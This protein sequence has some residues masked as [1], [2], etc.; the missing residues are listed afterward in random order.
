[1]GDNFKVWKGYSFIGFWK[2]VYLQLDEDEFKFLDQENGHLKHKIHPK[3]L[4]FKNEENSNTFILKT[5]VKNYRL[6]AKT[7]E[8]K[9]KWRDELSNN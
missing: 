9:E 7:T 8:I 3:C 4:S 6:K 1:M 2:S 5:G